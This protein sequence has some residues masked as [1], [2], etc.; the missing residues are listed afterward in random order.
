MIVHEGGH[1]AKPILY[2]TKG[3]GAAAIKLTRPDSTTQIIKFTADAPGAF[4]H[5]TAKQKRHCKEQRELTN[6]LKKN[7]ISACIP[8]QM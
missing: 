5:W 7:N 2:I 1:V 3:A 6:I 4:M 8:D